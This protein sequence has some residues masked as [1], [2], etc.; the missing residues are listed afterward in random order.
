MVFVI[1]Y[2]WWGSRK[3]GGSRWQKYGPLYVCIAATPLILADLVR[4]ILQDTGVWKECQRPAGEIWSSD[5]TWSSSQY[6]CTEAAPHGCIPT[7]EENL[8]N[9]SMIGWLFTIFF[10]YFGFALL[11]VGTMWNANIIDKCKDVRRKWRQLRA[12]E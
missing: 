2:L 10:T 6:H 8:T 4:H 12:T 7:K 11:I 9:L 5:C 1:L 3:R